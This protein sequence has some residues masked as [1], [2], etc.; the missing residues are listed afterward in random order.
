MN[1]Y[2]QFIQGHINILQ[3][4]INKL[5]P[6]GDDE[7]NRGQLFAYYKMLNK[8]KI[9]AFFEKISLKNIGLDKINK[10]ILLDIDNNSKIF[11]TIKKII[12]EWDPYNLISGGAPDNEFESEIIEIIFKIK[13]KNDI[14]DIAYIISDI[15]INSFDKHDLFSVENCM[16]IANKIKC[17]INYYV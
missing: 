8:L 5:I 4:E 6:E 2:R 15:F 10:N 12:N 13:G 17:G 14:K 9:G 7:F 3:E 1:K 16:D 11:Q